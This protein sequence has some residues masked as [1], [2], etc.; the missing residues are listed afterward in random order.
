MT[1]VDWKKNKGGTNEGLAR[2]QH[3]TRHD[4]KDVEYRNK[5][6]QK[7]KI[8]ENYRICAPG[9]LL[10]NRT[11]KDEIKRLED[12]VKVLDKLKPPQRIRKDRV[13]TVSLVIPVPDELHTNERQDF[14]HFSLVE[15]EDKE[16]KFFQIVYDE[17]AKFFGGYENL[18]YGYVHK[19][20]AHEYLDAR[21]N[22]LKMSKVHMQMQAVAWTESHGVNGKN[23]TSKARMREFNQRIDARCR[24]ELG[25]GF[26]KS[27]LSQHDR[28]YRS[29]EELKLESIRK[30][31]EEV[32][33]L[34]KELQKE[35]QEVD[36]YKEVAESLKNF[37]R[38]EGDRLENRA[39]QL[40]DENAKLEKENNN[41][42]N[43]SEA[44]K[45]KVKKLET[46]AWDI[47]NLNEE[48]FAL[49]ARNEEL[50][51]ENR[52]LK[53][54]LDIM[55]RAINSVINKAR[56]IFFPGKDG[57]K[58]SFWSELKRHMRLEL[59]DKD[60]DKFQQIRHEE[61]RSSWELN[62][63]KPVDRGYDR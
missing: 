6:V 52:G 43:Q 24:K 50:E 46:E 47:E 30:S 55:K 23:C 12:R 13:T 20:E 40:L 61:D 49:M 60:Y 19:D 38:D 9:E 31:R 7:D 39:K 53:R 27:D 41:L 45:E 29:V 3:A 18:T 25:I 34:E 1:S 4:G 11:A 14:P 26:L 54:S 33:K 63:S 17:A 59:G 32:K 21:D 57:A 15:D 28:N 10:K 16:R 36:D 44:L 37:Y 2:M 5:D 58:I 51:N 42:K 56:N 62:K 22:E 35:K 48:N 8:S